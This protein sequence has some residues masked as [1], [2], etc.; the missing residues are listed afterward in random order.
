MAWGDLEYL[1]VDLPPG[2][3]DV[4][5]TLAQKTPVSGGI[6]VCTPQNLALVDAIKAMDMFKEIQIPLLGVVENM[7][8]MK[9]ASQETPLQLFPKGQL[10]IFLKEHKVKKLAQIPFHPSIGLCAD[11][12]IPTVESAKDSIESQILIQLAQNIHNQLNH[13]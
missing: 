6:V 8:Y 2:T 5:L 1:I 11:S 13:S 4:T 10:D 7:S 3:G 12:G 9:M